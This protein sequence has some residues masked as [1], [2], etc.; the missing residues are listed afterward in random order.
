MSPGGKVVTSG[1]H[2]RPWVG[3][4]VEPGK[5]AL[6]A[7]GGTNPR[8]LHTVNRT[9]SLSSDMSP[10]TSRPKTEQYDVVVEAG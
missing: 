5:S 10:G 2:S 7:Q 1:A 6:R 9:T 4:V 3:I 8:G